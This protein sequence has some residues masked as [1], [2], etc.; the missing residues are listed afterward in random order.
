MLEELRFGKIW[1]MVVAKII[2]HL[3]MDAFFAA[4]E[5]LDS[6]EYRGKPVIVVRS[7]ERK[8]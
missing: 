8:G 7:P 4:V 3:D 6:P 1:D 5:Q 2:L